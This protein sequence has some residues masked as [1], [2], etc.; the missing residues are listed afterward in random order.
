ML[1]AG[2]LVIGKDLMWCGQTHIVYVQMP[3]ETQRNYEASLAKFCYL[4]L[5]P[6][7]AGMTR[8]ELH[9]VAR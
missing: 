6:A 5:I 8:L 9:Q 4:P 3:Y 1:P 2:Q 7:A